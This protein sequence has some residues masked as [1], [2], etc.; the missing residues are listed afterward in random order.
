MKP[1][2]FILT[3]LFN[4]EVNVYESNKYLYV[5]E[6]SWIIVWYE[7]AECLVLCDKLPMNGGMLTC[8]KANMFCVLLSETDTLWEKLRQAL[9]S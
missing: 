3:D 6:L 4:R 5:V 8:A 9:L 7:V 2:L 1:C